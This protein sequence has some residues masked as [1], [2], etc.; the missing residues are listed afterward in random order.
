VKERNVPLVNEL[1]VFSTPWHWMVHGLGLGQRPTGFD[2]D[3]AHRLSVLNRALLRRFRDPFQVFVHELT[4][5]IQTHCEAPPSDPGKPGAARGIQYDVQR[6]NDDKARMH[7]VRK[8][9][10]IEDPSAHARACALLVDSFLKLSFT[11]DLSRSADAVLRE[12]VATALHRL[13]LIPASS[14]RARYEKLHLLAGL[15]LAAGRA[16]WGDL[17]TVPWGPARTEPHGL[18]AAW[19]LLGSL[20]DP[21]YR[22]RG[23]AILFTVLGLVGLGADASRDGGDA[24]RALLDLLDTEFQRAPERPSD[25]V[26]EGRDYRLFPLSLTLIAVSVLGRRDALHYKR[27]WLDLAATEIERL[28][29]ASRASQALF[30]IAALRSLGVLET[31]VPAPA[32]W[33]GEV[34]DAYLGATDGQRADDDLRCTYLVH[35]AEQLGCSAALPPRVGEILA[36]SVARIGRSEPEHAHPYASGFMTLAYALSTLKAGG[37]AT[38]PWMARIDLAKVAGRIE[39]DPRRTALH[40][41]RL[42]M[43]LIDAALR[44]RPPDYTHP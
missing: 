5:A 20:S 28:T 29:P 35:L 23:A 33:L 27:D 15:F 13:T 36:G 42:N 6:D 9:A 43:A 32:A 18:A 44:L 2:V 7:L 17:I 21:F 37:P 41:P 24:L 25:G 31:Y 22:A 34:T 3:Q 14:E 11:L 12:S 26:H 4:K 16:G 38:A 39:A 19:H 10:Y 1:C 8:L 40:L 30:Y